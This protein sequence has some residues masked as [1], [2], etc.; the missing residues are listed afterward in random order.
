MRMS[1]EE[2]MQ[3]AL[4]AVF[5]AALVVFFSAVC[6][7]GATPGV[8]TGVTVYDHGDRLSETRGS[9]WQASEVHKSLEGIWDAARM[10]M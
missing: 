1:K 8:R 7:F 4:M 3:M 2:V 5:W 9:V 6:G 10:P